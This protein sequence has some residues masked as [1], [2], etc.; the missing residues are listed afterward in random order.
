VATRYKIAELQEAR[1][2]EAQNREALRGDML[3][4]I[5]AAQEAERQRIARE[6]HDE[7]GQSLTAIGLGIRAV[8]TSRADNP[9]RAAQNLRRLED[10]TAQ[11]ITE[12]RRIIADLRPSHLDDL[13]LA[14]TLRWYAGE[15]E[16]RSGLHIHLE[17]AGEE[18]PLSS[19]MTTTLFRLAQEA[20]T[21]VIRHAHATQA[22]VQLNYGKEEV[23]LT[24]EDDGLGFN[25]D[26]VN[27]STRSPFGLLGMRER[28]SLLGGVCTITSKLGKGTKVEVT[29]PY[30][31][32]G[33]GEEQADE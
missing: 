9:E 24:V 31:P 16:N 15:I 29:I 12:L 3:R 26:M 4:R 18:R 21:N 10:L 30:P 22:K 28:A 13:G 33:T 7:T 14:S 20:L 8:S 2:E 23:R 5:V 32:V 6:L 27:Y 1:L 25:P 17:Q 19:E 11:S